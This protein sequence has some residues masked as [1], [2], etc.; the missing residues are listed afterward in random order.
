[1][2]ETKKIDAINLNAVYSYM[3]TKD[4]KFCK[5]IFKRKKAIPVYEYLYRLDKKVDIP[6]LII[7]FFNFIFF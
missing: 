3:G 2:Q 5:F 7:I 1:M 4:K 6:I